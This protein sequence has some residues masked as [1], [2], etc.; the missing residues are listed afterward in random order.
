MIAF[1]NIELLV[2]GMKN[3]F[4]C[5]LWLWTRV[6]TNEGTSSLISFVD[7]LRSS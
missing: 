6:S 5:N 3:S 7:Y 1:D 2:Q 4:V